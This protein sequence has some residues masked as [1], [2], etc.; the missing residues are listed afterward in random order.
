MDWYLSEGQQVLVDSFITPARA[1]LQA[2]AGAAEVLV[3]LASL[4]AEEEEWTSRY[5]TVIGFGTVIE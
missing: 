5:E 1:D 2:A 4:S 3:D